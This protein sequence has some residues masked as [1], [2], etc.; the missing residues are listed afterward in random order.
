MICAHYDTRIDTPGAV[1]NGAGV[2]ALLTLARLL[3]SR[4]LGIGLEFVAFS[5]EE[6]GGLCDSEYVRHSG[7]EL[8]SVVAAVNIDG[9][10][11]TLGA[12]TV[13]ISSAEL[14]R[15]SRAGGRAGGAAPRR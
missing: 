6:Y 10:G 15:A 1:D 14:R 12:T 4:Q 9:I 5:A 3:T 13:A 2:A 7:D 11:L 8:G